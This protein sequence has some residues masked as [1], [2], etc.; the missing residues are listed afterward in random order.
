MSPKRAVSAALL[1]V[2]MAIAGVASASTLDL[3]APNVMTTSTFGDFLV[4]SLELNQQ[5][6]AA[7][8]PRCQPFIASQYPV[9]ANEGTATANELV[10]YQGSTGNDNTPT[11]FAAL[12]GALF[13]NPFRAPEG[14]ASSFDM[15]AANEPGSGGVVNGSAEFTG[16]KIGTW[17]VRISDLLTYLNG[18]D[19]VFL[20]D[21]NQSGSLS[22]QF[23]GAWGQAQ[24]T[25]AAGNQVGANCFELDDGPAGCGT[26][27]P[28][29]TVPPFVAVIGDFCVDKAT[30][31]AY[32]T[33]PT[34]DG[35]T[36][37]NAGQCS[38]ANNPTHP[39]GGYFISNNLGNNAEF[40]IFNQALNDAVYNPANASNFLTLNL[41]LRF[42]SDGSEQMWIC[43]DCNVPNAIIAPAVPEPATVLLVGTGLVALGGLAWRR[44][45]RK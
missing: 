3:P 41:K 31:E 24:I 15:S 45:K 6:G 16:D 26:T 5:C 37:N 22:T 9:S 42:L 21:N 10:V 28:A 38:A 12:S 23:L 32:R 44:S 11:P 27:S 29:S 7:G 33:G 17:Q 25:D 34:G 2:T 4:Y 30:G 43:S 20:F 13:D 8:D 19:L 1:A 36:A 39:A 35:L 14:S 40:A 18:N